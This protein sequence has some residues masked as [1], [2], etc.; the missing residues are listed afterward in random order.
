MRI[1][2]LEP[3]RYGEE[4]R[5]LLEQKAVVDYVELS[6]ETAFLRALSSAAYEAVF[7]RL[8]LE[9]DRKAM[10][11]CPS[12][13]WIVTPTTGLNHIDLQAAR[14]RGIQ[15][16]SLKGETAYLQ[17]IR[18]TSEHTMAL[19]LALIRQ[20]PAA[21][22]AVARNLWEREPFLGRELSGR[23]LGIIGYGRLGKLVAR[24][25]QA[26][27]MNVLVYDTDENQV[28][29]LPKGIQKNT[30]EKLLATSDFVSLHIPGGVENSGF[31]DAEKFARM[32]PGAFLVNTS[33]GEVVDEEALLHAL[34]SGHLAGAALDVLAGDSSWSGRVPGQHPL[35]AFAKC[36]PNLLITPHIGGYARE[37]LDSTRLFVVKK[38]LKLLKQSAQ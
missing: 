17:S 37:S 2:H 3:L 21:T 7:V 30:L 23:T 26:F 31:F 15:I 20:I 36:N 25:A 4:A 11:A 32:K 16:V 24:Y 6:G 8:G 5:R 38:F 19:L 13:N 27:F 18:S 14:E 9:L 1:L 34:Q 33:R 22:G 10:E 35:V 28:K 29:H 12:L